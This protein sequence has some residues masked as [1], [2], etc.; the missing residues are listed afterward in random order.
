MERSKCVNGFR[1]IPKIFAGLRFLK[2]VKFE[3]NVFLAVFNQFEN[4]KNPCK[5]FGEGCKCK[6]AVNTHHLHILN[7]PWPLLTFI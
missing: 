3:Q 5:N 4:L 1:R 6:L 2:S 7:N